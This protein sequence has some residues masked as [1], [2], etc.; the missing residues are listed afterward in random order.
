MKRDSFEPRLRKWAEES[1]SKVLG[2]H[3]LRVVIVNY[4]QW[5]STIDLV[6]Q[7][8]KSI[9][10]RTGK[11][12]IVVVDNGSPPNSLVAKLNKIPNLRLVRNRQNKGFARA[13]NIGADGFNG[14]WLLL[15]NPDIT[16]GE[17]FLDRII[18]VGEDHRSRH[19]NQGVIGFGMLDPEGT[20]QPSTGPFPSLINTIFRR[21]LPRRFRKYHL[22]I[23][24]DG[25]VDWAS[26][27]C[28]LVTKACWSALGRFDPDFFLYYEDVDFCQ[29]AVKG[30]WRV[31]L[32]K[33]VT[34]VHHHP[35]HR[36]K[37]PG[38]LRV[39]TRMALY[40][41]TRK[42]WPKWQHFAMSVILKTEASLGVWYSRLCG[43]WVAESWWVALGTLLRDSTKGKTS[44]AIQRLFTLLGTGELHRKG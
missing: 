23:P 39:A 37:V 6:R 42:H 13:V 24:M 32:D 20:V 1:A 44:T 43:N 25:K 34:A 10:W 35:L 7:L 21:F 2:A 27:C 41:Y 33:S 31:G 9:S 12:E 18:D 40:T 22:S 16:V 29:R 30:G 3:A 15:L 4:R 5:S 36:R 14:E 28:L 26:G 38:H 17:G 11:I 8:C 19:V